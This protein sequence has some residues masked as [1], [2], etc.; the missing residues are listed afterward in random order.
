MDAA[1]AGR[2]RRR[3]GARRLASV[4]E[5][6]AGL[7]DVAPG[8]VSAVVGGVLH[9]VVLYA[10]ASEGRWRARG[11]G[12]R[13]DRG[14]LAL[15]AV[16]LL[17]ALEASTT[18]YRQTRYTSET[19]SILAPLFVA[20]WFDFGRSSPL[21]YLDCMNV[22][23]GLPAIVAIGVILWRREWRPYRQAGLVL[24]ACL[25]LLF[26]PG[27]VV[28]YT[29]VRL[30]GLDRALQS[31][32]FLEGAAAMAAL[33]T[34]IAIGR[35]LKAGGGAPVGRAFAVVGAIG[36]WVGWRG[37][38]GA[39]GY[40][41]AGVTAAPR[42][43]SAEGCGRCA[44]RR[45]GEGGGRGGGPGAGVR[46]LSRV[47]DEPS[48]QYAGREVPD[49]AAPRGI[50]EAVW[51]T[52]R[53]DRQHRVTSDGAPSSME[54]RMWG[55]TSPQGLDPLLPDAYRRRIEGWGAEFQTTRI[56]RMPYGN[57]EM[58]RALGVRYAISYHGAASEAELADAS[59]FRPVG[60]DDSF[61][62]VY[63]YTGARA[64]HRWPGEARAVE[65]LPERR[66]YR[67][68]SAGG[69]TFGLVEQFYPGWR[70]T[71]DGRPVEVARWQGAFQAIE[72]P[73]GEHT[74]V[75]AYRSR[76]LRLGAGIS[77]VS[78]ALLGWAASA[79]IVSRRR[80]SRR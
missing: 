13:R 6:G 25:F 56:F 36:V 44:R 64:S 10:A 40:P 80:R 70:A 20:N 31:Y 37:W 73:A 32:N 59:R 68:S 39:T 52:M 72:V 54:F 22:Y 60:P 63:E 49:T 65:W 30:P 17:P 48:F 34:A 47:R 78:L 41:A 79:S 57:D 58:L 33:G 28:Y 19:K 12:G 8:G 50:N 7:G 4:V 24:G 26:D 61:Y 62:R 16:Q 2:D 5:D 15:A 1:G 45:D 76:W 11:G 53:D 42:C 9:H 43:C 27:H 14:S 35:F 69:G 51:R 55:L 75:F 21:S 29:I 38:A 3:G 67:V 77:G 18:M 71:V 46:G 74:V 66:A 23:W